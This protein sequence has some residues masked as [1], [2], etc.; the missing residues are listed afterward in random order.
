ME[1][2]PTSVRFITRHLG[3]KKERTN[4]VSIDTTEPTLIDPTAIMGENRLHGAPTPSSWESEFFGPDWS[5][6]P[7]GEQPTRWLGIGIGIAALAV[8]LAAFAVLTLLWDS[9]T[10]DGATTVQSTDEAD[11]SPI[12]DTTEPAVAAAPSEASQPT[13]ANGEGETAVATTLTPNAV[14]PAAAST[15]TAEDAIAVFMK[16]WQ[17]GEWDDMG[18][19]A[20]AEAVDVARTW[21]PGAATVYNTN[22]AENGIDFDLLVDVGD[23]PAQLFRA[24]ITIADTG[25]TITSLVHTGD[26]G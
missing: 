20:G 24:E 11:E 8:I 16:A 21:G 7:E 3:R 19:V 1:D 17:V 4:S 18:T 25:A 22:E 15:P 26:A 5:E 23:G 9:A 12:V 10:G 14:E 13:E 6:D 2:R